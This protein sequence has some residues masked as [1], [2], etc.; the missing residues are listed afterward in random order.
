MTHFKRTVQ[1]ALLISLA[2]L[3]LSACAPL[4]IGGTAT[5]VLVANDRR[6]SGA[7]LE[8]QTIEIK[9]LGNINNVVGDRGHINVTS[10]NRRV[11]VTGE[12]PSTGDKSA[13]AG[14]LSKTDNVQLVVNELVIG[15]AATFA[16]R[17]RDTLV[18][19][20]VKASMIEARDL[21]A[22]IVKVVTERGSVYLMGIVTQ[23]EADRAS[24]VA[25]ST[26]G[27]QRVVRLFEIVTEEELKRLLPPPPPPAPAVKTQPVMTNVVTE[28][29]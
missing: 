29:K 6:T 22:S 4:L 2:T 26:S 27:V 15:G 12:V 18:T 7:Q 21:Q 10:F 25:S 9:S 5:G 17:A 19:T 14:S 3:T 20:R 13:V 16:N 11:L 28:I 23:R 8:D 1:T 24:E